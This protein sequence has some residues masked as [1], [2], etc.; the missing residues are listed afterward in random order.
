M[1][2]YRFRRKLYAV[3]LVAAAARSLMGGAA[4]IMTKPVMA[5]VGKEI[6]TNVAVDK[7]TKILTGG[8]SEENSSIFDV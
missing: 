2:T 8:G 4:K 7:G 6:A 1:A 3:P 5:K